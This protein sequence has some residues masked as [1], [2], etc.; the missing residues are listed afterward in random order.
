V[1]DTS[2]FDAIVGRIFDGE[3][4]LNVRAAA[5]RGALPLPRATLIQIY[6][7]LLKDD[8]EEVRGAAKQSLDGLS[9]D[10]VGEALE[11]PDCRPEVLTHF[12]RHAARQEN[13]AEKLAFHPAVPAQALEILAFAGSAPV[14]EL[15]LTNQERLLA[16]PALLEKL[17]L[18]P[19]LRAEQRGRILELLDRVSKETRG[20]GDE[21]EP[22]AEAGTEEADLE[23]TA[24]LLDVDV[25]DL[26]SY[27]EIMDGEEF[28]ESEDPEI[29][30]T[31]QKIITLNA[32]AKAILAM[33]GGREERM[34]LVRDTNKVVALAVLKNGRI[35]EQEVES[36]AK[37]RNVTE[38]V[39]RSVGNSREWTKNYPVILALV[40]NP[41]T[42]QGVTTN[43]I[44]RLTNRDLKAVFMSR[45]IP[46]LIRRMA[47]R[48]HDIRTQPQS[49]KLRKK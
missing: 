21:E 23:E 41:R 28:A 19:A 34:I 4:S 32:A 3:A 20:G 27:S 6:V 25:G 37:M 15:V 30:N 42:P 17:M 24:R 35:T 16:Q 49:G 46:E 47:R 18:N 31:Y 1:S 33:K 7:R 39:L 44:S 10:A 14:L 48:T 36:I 40:T 2:P 29:R 45:D 12:A 22:G 13:L 8:D 11:D 38:E 9:Q 5:A 43:F 26:L